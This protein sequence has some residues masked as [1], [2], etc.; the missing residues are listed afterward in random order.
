M[1][2]ELILHLNFHLLLIKLNNDMIINKY[3]II[4]NGNM[5]YNGQEKY[6][7]EIDT[8][9]K[10]E[11]CVFV[12]CDEEI[13]TKKRIQTNREILKYVKNNYYQRYS[14]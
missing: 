1:F 7:K 6:I 9:C 2:P 13:T 5:G 8:K 10:Q 11:K 14:S 3:D 4:N 12:I